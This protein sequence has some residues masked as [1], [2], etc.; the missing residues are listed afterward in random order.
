MS[1]GGIGGVM[2]SRRHHARRGSMK[3][4]RNKWRRG[5][6]WRRRREMALGNVGI[7]RRHGGIA[8]SASRR[9]SLFQLACGENN[10]RRSIGVIVINNGGMK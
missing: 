5:G 2:A 9:R 10:R 7:A 3:W 6:S 4:R 1:L 8:R